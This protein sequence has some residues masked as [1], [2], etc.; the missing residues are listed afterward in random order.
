MSADPGPIRILAVDDHQVHRQGVAQRHERI[1][2]NHDGTEDRNKGLK[3]SVEILSR[4]PVF[5]DNY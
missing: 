4:K 3:T 5:N 1:G 2:H